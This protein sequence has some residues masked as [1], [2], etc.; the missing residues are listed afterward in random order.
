MTRRPPV[1]SSL[2]SC[3]ALFVSFQLE[4]SADPIALVT[5]YKKNR[6]LQPVSILG[7]MVI[8]SKGCW[9]ADEALQKVQ[10]ACCA[11][12]VTA[13]STCSAPESRLKQRQ[14]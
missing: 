10:C 13:G 2:P 9:V 3:A 4:E 14:I 5:A 1:G 11:R 7:M 12:R 8:C 6:P